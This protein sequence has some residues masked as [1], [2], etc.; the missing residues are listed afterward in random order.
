[1]TSDIL[2]LQ[3]AYAADLTPHS[4]KSNPFFFLSM[5]PIKNHLSKVPDCY[6][7]VRV[8]LI[9]G[10]FGTKGTLKSQGQVFAT[11]VKLENLLNL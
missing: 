11:Y 8:R 3:L 2:V 7:V 9:Y 5:S 10:N 1:M 4:K 6:S